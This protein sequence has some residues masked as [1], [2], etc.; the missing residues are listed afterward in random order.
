MRVSVIE[1]ENKSIKMRM[2]YGTSI[3]QILQ[4]WDC[5]QNNKL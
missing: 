4:I 1:Y 3:L 2:L 5:L